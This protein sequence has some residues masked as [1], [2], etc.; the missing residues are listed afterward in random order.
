MTGRDLNC[1]S[2]ITQP[3]HLSTRAPNLLYTK[4]PKYFQYLILKYQRRLGEKD[5]LQFP[6]DKPT[7]RI[8]ER[9]SE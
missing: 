2:Q 6:D 4:S 1:G 7:E 5:S 8:I 9:W 3:R